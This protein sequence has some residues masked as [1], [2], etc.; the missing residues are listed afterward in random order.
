M[1]GFKTDSEFGYHVSLDDDHS[2]AEGHNIFELCEDDTEVSALQKI[3]DCYFDTE[4]LDSIAGFND[5]KIDFSISFLDTICLI[6]KQKIKEVN[7]Q[8][9]ELERQCTDITHHMTKPELTGQAFTAEEK[10]K[11]F[12]EQQALLI[13]RRRVKD[14]LSI[15]RAL[16]ENM[17]KSRNFILGMNRRMYSPKSEK[18]KDDPEYKFESKDR[19]TA[20]TNISNNASTG[21]TTVSIQEHTLS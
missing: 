21:V 6:F 10:I 14:T 17:E 4:T 20:G 16:L 11:L 8:F 19:Q 7:I 12:D 1:S 18:F 5:Y 9:N 3:L 13:Q 2:F 15:M